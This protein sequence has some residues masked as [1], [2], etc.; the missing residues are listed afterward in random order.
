MTV[1]RVSELF[2]II[3][4]LGISIAIVNRLDCDLAV[5]EFVISKP[6]FTLVLQTYAF[7]NV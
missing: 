5:N 6:S 2:R 1:I 7:L 3:C 4:S